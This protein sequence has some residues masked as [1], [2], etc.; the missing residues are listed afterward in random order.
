[1]RFL[2]GLNIDKLKPYFLD[3]KDKLNPYFLDLK[4]KLN[5]TF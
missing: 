2:S 5:H 1:M 4:A 3:L